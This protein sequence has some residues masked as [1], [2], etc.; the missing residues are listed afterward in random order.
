L[1]TTA[2]I[3]TTAAVA[4]N[5]NPV[6]G[7]IYVYGLTFIS[8]V[9]QSAG[10]SN[11]ALFPNSAFYYFDA[12][13]F[14][15]ASTAANTQIVL[16]TTSA[17]AIV[18][19]N[20]QVSF[21]N[22]AQFVAFGTT[23][24]IWQNTGQVLVSG[25]S[26]PT[27]LLGQLVPAG[28]SSVTLEAL[29]LSQVTSVFATATISI[30]NWVV[31]DC[32]LNASVTFSNP[33][34]VG[35]IVQSIRADGGAT[36]YKSARYAYEG[37]ETTETSVTRVGGASDP[38]GQA[39]SRKIATT[40]NSQWL[41]PFKAEPYAIW[42]PTT[43]STVTVTVYGTINA[44]ALPNNDDIWLEVEYLGSASFPVGTIVAT[45]KSNLLAANAAVASDGSTWNGGGSGAGWSPFKLVA[46]LSSPQ[47]GMAGYLHA[48]VRAAK[49]STT[50]YIDPKIVLT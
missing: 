30:G 29:D 45:T 9:G 13:N 20:G 1:K 17:G 11:I 19:N 39:Q 47:P 8:G 22:I 10:S 7:A 4:I 42:N 43:G 49:P 3:S 12:C 14:K 35:Q 38:T 46:T 27:N 2:T 23:S 37:T 26:V 40:A 48:R 44:G 5:F 21:A 34:N 16:N 41:R 6:S 32:K 36:A 18:W 50:F 28:L 31:K 15:L 25:S 24:F 33:S